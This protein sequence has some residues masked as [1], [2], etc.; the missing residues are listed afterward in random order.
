MTQQPDYQEQKQKNEDAFREVARSVRPD[1]WS[2]MDALDTYEINY[3]VLLKTLEHLH[4][5]ATGTKFGTVTVEIQDNIVTFIR[6]LE[7]SRLNE[8]LS[9]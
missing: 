4:K 1:V 9:K 7:S 8:A 3:I 2:L 6:S 5:V